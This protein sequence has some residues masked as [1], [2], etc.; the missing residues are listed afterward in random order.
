M[1]EVS[2]NSKLPTSAELEVFL[3]D[4]LK[5]QSKAVEAVVRHYGA[6]HSGLK[7]L[8]ETDRNKPIGI[9]F[10]L[11]PSGTGKSKLGRLVA[12]AIYGTEDAAACFDMEN[13]NL[14]HSIARFIGS[15]PGYIKCNEPAELS[16][17]KLLKRI[18]NAQT[19]RQKEKD[20][21]KTDDQGRKVY[22]VL[23]E[24]FLELK[25][26]DQS[27]KIGE[28]SLW[29][30]ELDMI[31]RVLSEQQS[32][33]EELGE[34]LQNLRSE[35]STL[36]EGKSN[37]KVI[38]E[39]KNKI[40]SLLSNINFVIIY[41][42]HLKVRRAQVLA[43]YLLS[44]EDRLAEWAALSKA[45]YKSS[46]KQLKK[47]KKP[48]KSEKVEEPESENTSTL[49]EE[50]SPVLV[51]I[52]NEFEKAHKAIH[53]FFLNAMSS[54]RM[55]LMNGE[56]L[57]LRR[58]LIF[59]TSNVGS[60]KMA[61][62]L[63]SKGWKIGFM[64]QDGARSRENEARKELREKFN[65]E[66]L[67]RI[68]EIVVFNDLADETMLE[69]LDLQLKDFSLGL[70]KLSVQLDICEEVRKFIIAQSRL[71]PEGQAHGLLKKIKSLLKIP[72]SQMLEKGKIEEGK[73]VV[74]KLEDNKIIFSVI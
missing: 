6:F 74:A 5:G 47:G 20:E 3:K 69:I 18:P 8:S 15:P 32:Q 29:H 68:D 60:A 48:K 11:G 26:R 58:S 12:Q 46:E 9:F 70:Q 54:G 13:F 57:D 27:I 52:F 37:K 53:N 19:K 62:I 23:T 33:L 35:L 28:L 65:P 39:K 42:R 64:R 1:T 59:F 4:N 10:F 24:K 38:A 41:L 63:N 16:P 49:S 67:N 14:S 2:S 21:F 17:E 22:R 61:K 71:E 51:L 40:D 25:E 66:F 45:R 36:R 55:V 73:T 31:D 43:N 34:R 72:I 50:N 7:N 56:E 44:L 30:S